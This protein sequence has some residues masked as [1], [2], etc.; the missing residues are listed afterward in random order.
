MEKFVNIA[1]I[2]GGKIK[3]EIRITAE[4]WETSNSWG[5]TAELFDLDNFKTVGY[6]KCQYD[7]RTWES[8]R[9]QTALHG[10][11]A[12]YVKRVTGV[13]PFKPICKRDSHQMKDFGA[14][15]RRLARLEHR[16]FARDLYDNLCGI[17]DGTRTEAEI[18]GWKVA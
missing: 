12:D 15:Y 11:I 5:H 7:N 1:N 3:G 2:T 4:Y 17:V 14:E 18:A 6:C 8:Y 9:F 16:Q 13:N 10:A